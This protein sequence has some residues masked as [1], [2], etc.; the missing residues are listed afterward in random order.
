MKMPGLAKC[1]SKAV[2]PALGDSGFQKQ[3]DQVDQA[4]Q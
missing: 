4:Y 3:A 1:L 2:I